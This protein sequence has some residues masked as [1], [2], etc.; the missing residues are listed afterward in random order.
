MGNNGQIKVLLIEDDIL[1]ANLIM[2]FLT[3][4]GM[5]FHHIEDGDL[6]VDT[7]KSI[8]PQIIILDWV[9][10]NKS[11]LDI[12]KEIRANYSGKI[13][14][15]TARE[16]IAD[17]LSSLLEGVDDY[18]RK[19]VDPDILTARIRLLVDGNKKAKKDPNKISYG[20]LTIDQD[21]QSVSV[22][23][24]RIEITNAEFDLLWMLISHKNEV[25]TR[26]DLLRDLR[27]IEYDGTDRT[28]DNRIVKLRKKLGDKDRT[29]PGIQSVRSAG[30][31][32]LTE[33]W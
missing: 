31:R 25:V 10:P 15:L 8:N 13:L 29:A 18:I 6:A 27:G 16:G 9:L 12:C 30:Y 4:S 1:L 3:P 28:I 21:T 32:F 17:E 7:I 11:G 20:R 26:E 33:N 24:K 23:G 2:K 14:M 22:H 5:D 19:P